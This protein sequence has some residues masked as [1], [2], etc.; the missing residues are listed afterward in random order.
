MHC[1]LTSVTETVTH[2]SNKVLRVVLAYQDKHP[3]LFGWKKNREGMCAIASLLLMNELNKYG[4]STCF[5]TSMNHCFLMLENNILDITA[6]Q[7]GGIDQ[8]I[9][10][11]DYYEFLNRVM[12]NNIKNAQRAEPWEIISRFGSVED[13]LTRL[14]FNENQFNVQHWKSLAALL[15]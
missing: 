12:D 9:I 8:D 7:F 2:M 10:F 3:G 4:L 13:V 1:Y 11:E 5:V 14:K 6:T 15:N